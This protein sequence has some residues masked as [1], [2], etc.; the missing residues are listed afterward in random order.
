VTLTD[1]QKREILAEVVALTTPPQKEPGDV[2]VKD[3]AKAAGC[4][5]RK[6]YNRLMALGQQDGW[7]TVKVLDSGHRVW[8]LRKVAA[9]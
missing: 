4:T 8:A 9:C 6:A 5:Q 7:E 3:L 1:E 2:T